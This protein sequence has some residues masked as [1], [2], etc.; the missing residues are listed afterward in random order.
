MNV[1]LGFV[2]A[3]IEKYKKIIDILSQQDRQSEGQ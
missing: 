2:S 3:L 1:Q